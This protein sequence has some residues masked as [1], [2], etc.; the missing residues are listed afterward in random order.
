M[1][2]STT[3]RKDTEEQQCA[4][5]QCRVGNDSTMPRPRI[6]RLAQRGLSMI[7]LGLVL[8]VVA[9]IGVGVYQA[10]ANQQRRTEIDQ[11]QAVISNILGALQA[12]F[13]KTN[14]YGDITT[15]VAVQSRVFPADL[16]IGT[17]NTAQNSY[18]GLI[19]AAPATCVSTNDCAT[20]SWPS[21]PRA[22]CSEI[23]TLVQPYARRVQIGTTD[24]KPL[25]GALNVG[26]LSTTCDGA[27]THTLVFTVGRG[28]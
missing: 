1:N 19:E 5:G 4:G 27:A 20:L 23:V 25:D 10:F 16:R 26:T 6:L 3:Q 7:E 17:T 9:I 24:V 15:A 2:D 8:I 12:Q 13:G 14:T 28:A 22:Q 18:G 11:N 21:V